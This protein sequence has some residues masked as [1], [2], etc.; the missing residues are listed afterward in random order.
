MTLITREDIDIFKS[1]CQRNQEQLRTAVTAYLEGRYP[2]IISTKEYVMAQGTIPVLL[3]AHLDTVF[4][5]PPSE[6]YYDRAQRVMWSPQGLGAD[7]RAGVFAI[8][9]ILDAG[10][11]PSV[12][13]TT[14]EEKMGVGATIV[15][16]L[17]PEIPFPDTKFIIELDRQGE[18]DSVFYDCDNKEFEKFI[19]SYK[20]ETDYGSFSDISIL[21]PQWKL[22][23]VNLSVGYLN[24]HFPI[25]TLNMNWLSQ[26]ILK[27]C[28]IL[29]DAEAAQK[30]K[31]IKVKHQSSVFF[32]PPGVCLYCGKKLKIGEGH[33]IQDQDKIGMFH[34]TICN[35][36]YKDLSEC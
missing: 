12:L 7:D 6:I 8:L 33:E 1:L 26:T 11:R 22:A 16:R 28:S 36:C 2:R 20:F 13:F 9:K 35:S 24:E 25:E 14:D 32:S 29:K 21:A 17:Y 23:A 10:F 5:N 15:A 3:V 27:V 19:N 30:F 4:R 18:K 31:Y 34:Y